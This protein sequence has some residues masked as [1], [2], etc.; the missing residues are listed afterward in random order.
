[1]KLAGY[2]RDYLDQEAICVLLRKGAAWSD[3]AWFSLVGCYW[4]ERGQSHIPRFQTR[5]PRK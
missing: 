3:P 5:R 1:V 2:D 4:V